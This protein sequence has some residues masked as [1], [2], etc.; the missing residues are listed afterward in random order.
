MWYSPDGRHLAFASFN[1]TA[2]KD[3]AYFHYGLPGSLDDQY[4]TEVKI[5][6]P[7]VR[8]AILAMFMRSTQNDTK[9]NIAEI[10]LSKRRFQR[11]RFRQTATDEKREVN[12]EMII[13]IAR[14]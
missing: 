4:P 9:A 6:Y 5:K 7:K 2:V 8:V 12:R 14:D 11:R 13:F 10:L 3:M 1:D